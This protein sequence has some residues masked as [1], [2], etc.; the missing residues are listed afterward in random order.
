MVNL[1]G[2]L[3]GIGH[4]AHWNIF[5]VLGTLVVLGLGLA[6][7]QVARASRKESPV[8]ALYI[9]SALI[10]APYA[11][12]ADM[13]MLL[14]AMLLA[15]DYVAALPTR[16]APEKLIYFS[17]IFLFLGPVVLMVLGGHYWWNS[18]I[19]LMFPLIVLFLIAL[20][21]EICLRRSGERPGESFQA[22][23]G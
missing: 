10:T 5:V 2:F 16:S 6:S 3:T 21:L 22:Q 13:T 14:L 4:S 1:R 20:A 17:C 15:M 9:T 11:H 7:S 8:F 23:T 19:Y 12:F 18:R